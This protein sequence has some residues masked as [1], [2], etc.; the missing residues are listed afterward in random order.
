MKETSLEKSTSVFNWVFLQRKI[1]QDEKSKGGG[2]G[3]GWQDYDVGHVGM[4]T[5]LVQL[6]WP[7]L[8]T[9]EWLI[10]WTGRGSLNSFFKKSTHCCTKS[11]INC[12]MLL[13]HSRG[14]WWKKRT[15]IHLT[16]QLCRHVVTEGADAARAA[17][18]L[19][20][21]G[22]VTWLSLWTPGK[23]EALLPTASSL[24]HKPE[25]RYLY[26]GVHLSVPP[27]NVVAR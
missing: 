4:P 9:W 12:L 18:L 25:L 26:T 23:G 6:S 5:R 20:T 10:F 22:N 3:G 14:T 19:A 8:W 27:D 1:K 24:A 2:G 21:R 17:P 13:K 11:M 7:G 16:P 15:G